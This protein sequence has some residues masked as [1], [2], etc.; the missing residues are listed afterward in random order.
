MLPGEEDPEEEDS[1]VVDGV[2]LGEVEDIVIA[3]HCHLLRHCLSINDHPKTPNLLFPT[4]GPL[5]QSYKMPHGMLSLYQPLPPPVP[6]LLQ[7]VFGP[8][9]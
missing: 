9:K 4:S 7:P 2:I 3:T 1:G 5:L 8:P 6:L